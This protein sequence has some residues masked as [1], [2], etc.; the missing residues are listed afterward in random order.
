LVPVVLGLGPGADAL[1]Q[2]AQAGAER[3]SALQEV[4]VTATKR[5]STVQDT[6]ISMTAVTGKEIE[7]RGLTDFVSLAQTVPGI[8][9][10]SS[11]AGQTEFEMRG[12]T[13]SGGNS[14]TVGFYLDDTPMSAPAAA[15]N[16]KVVIDPNLYDLNRVE[17]LRGPQGTLYGSGSMGG[18]IKIVTNQPNPEAFDFSG[19]LILSDTDGG[20]FNHGESG[21]I[22][23]PIGGG[24]AALRV[25]GVY[26][27]DSGWIDRI[28]IQ[29]P[30]FPLETGCDPGGFCSTRGN[31]AGAFASFGGQDF[32]GV[33]DK[34]LSGVRLALLLKPNENLSITPSFLYQ[35]ISMGG[36]SQID[37]DPG[38]YTNYQ[39]F[40]SAEP[41]TDRVDLGSLNIQYHFAGADLT[42]VTSYW[43]RDEL[44]RQDGSEELQWVLTTL[45]GPGGPLAG[46][47]IPIPI[48]ADPAN[49]GFGQT[50]P[51]PLE[52]DKSWQTTEELRLESAGDTDFKWLVGYFYQDFESDW[53][54]FVLQPGAAPI[55]GT[56]NAFTQYQPTKIIQN[57]FFGE[58][59]YRFTP[60]WTA[61]AGLRRYSY[62]NEVT[63]SVSGYLSSTGSDAVSTLTNNE[64]SQGVNPKL[65]LSYQPN[66]DLLV[67]ATASK[68]FRPGGANQP[69]PVGNVGLGPAC[70][71]NLQAI[72]GTNQFV[73]APNTFDPDSVWTYELGEKWRTSDSH[74]VLNGAA[75]YSRWS[76]AQQFV[77][78]SCGFNFSTNTGDADIYGAELELDAVM[79]QGLVFALNGAY[80]HAYFQASTVLPGVIAANGLEVQDVPEWTS[81]ASLSYRVPLS[82]GIDFTSHLENT[83][84]ASRQEVTFA[85]YSIPSYD[86]TNLRL[87]LAGNKWSATMFANN[88]FNKLAQISNAYQINVGIASFQRATVAQP[89]TIGVELSYK[90]Q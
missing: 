51:T 16:G 42:S 58:V 32:K 82:N 41:F 80:T 56:G 18:T 6:P 49:C 81:N 57:S 87:G 65:N 77:P 44:L 75:Y 5:N 46:C 48:Y 10:K 1:A 71:A 11:G 8:S 73:P 60:E 86:L 7:Q 66:R 47:P 90:L 38:T 83:Y 68:G 84:V 34:A 17:V 27:H 23:L 2:Q 72:Y 67:Y 20:G 40:D 53:D 28:V 63:T 29:A 24:L 37:T 15:Q 76:N 59:S 70:E 33:N 55:V 43:T 52:D 22:N 9:M 89:R 12:M 3:V 36:L 31:V 85:L 62:N 25:V 30:N 45:A 64:S 50:T 4:I 39:A 19:K 21:M 88:L 13:S 14:A 69:V 74:V 26:A 78:I 61:T 54:L 35:K 79:A